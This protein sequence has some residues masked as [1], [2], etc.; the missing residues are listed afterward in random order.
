MS[1]LVQHMM[2]RDH[3]FGIPIGVVIDDNSLIANFSV[4]EI[5]PLGRSLLYFLFGPYTSLFLS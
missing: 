3:V 4:R 5:W 1:S 2:Q